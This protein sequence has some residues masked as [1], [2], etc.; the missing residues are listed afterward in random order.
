MI[1]T[2]APAPMPT[3]LTEVKD[4]PPPA[5]SYVDGPKLLLVVNAA[6]LHHTYWSL[7]QM[8]EAIKLANANP[9]KVVLV[10]SL[11][12]TAYFA[13]GFSENGRTIEMLAKSLANNISR[14]L[15]KFSAEAISAV[16]LHE[17]PPSFLLHIAMNAQ[18]PLYVPY[19]SG[20]VFQKFLRLPEVSSPD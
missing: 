6:A 16:I 4:T 2:D 11:D 18:W 19:S 13:E 1:A 20:G 7:D 12:P 5:V 8:R 17:P 9:D 3:P 15:T 14:Q 10:V